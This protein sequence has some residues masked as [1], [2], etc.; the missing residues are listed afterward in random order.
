MKVCL[1]RLPASPFPLV[2]GSTFLL[3]ALFPAMAEL[4]PTGTPFLGAALPAV[5]LA[6]RREAN[7]TAISQWYQQ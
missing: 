3:A 4:L 7:G 6:S 2:A 5:V 1:L